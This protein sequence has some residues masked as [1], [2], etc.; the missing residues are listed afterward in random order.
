MTADIEA[1]RTWDANVEMVDLM[2]ILSFNLGASCRSYR[3]SYRSTGPW[4]CAA[5]DCGPIR[6]TCFY[7]SGDMRSEGDVSTPLVAR[8]FCSCYNATM[9][10]GKSRDEPYSLE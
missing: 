1:L 7:P 4:M 6:G 10:E 5:D 9:F 2:E 8:K 3:L